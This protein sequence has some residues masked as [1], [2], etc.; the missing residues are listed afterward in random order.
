MGELLYYEDPP[1]N[2]D[3]YATRVL[4]FWYSGEC[5]LLSE[6]TDLITP[7]YVSSR[8]SQ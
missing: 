2:K 7:A 3:G 1:T 4:P 6:I 8:S 5:L